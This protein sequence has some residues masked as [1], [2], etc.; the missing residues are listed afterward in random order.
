MDPNILNLNNLQNILDKLS[1]NDIIQ[2]CRTNQNFYQYCQSD[3]GKRYIIL[4]RIHEILDIIESEPGYTEDLLVKVLN[5][6]APNFYDQNDTLVDFLLKNSNLI[7][8][9]KNSV[10]KR[11]KNR[12]SGREKLIKQWQ[13]KQL[14]NSIQLDNQIQQLQLQQR[15]VPRGRPSPQKNYYTNKLKNK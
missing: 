10:L 4:R 7:N 6:I 11:I 3:L 15:A 8:S 14:D 2:T 12:R 5:E 9:I 13:K 1:I